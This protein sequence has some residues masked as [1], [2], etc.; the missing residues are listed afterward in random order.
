[1]RGLPECVSCPNVKVV[2]LPFTLSDSSR[3]E[4]FSAL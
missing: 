2:R 3:L 4:S 1:M